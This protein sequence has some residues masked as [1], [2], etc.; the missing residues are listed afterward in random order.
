MT[1]ISRMPVVREVRRRTFR[2]TAAYWEN[3]YA[4]GGTSGA[5]S[6]GRQAEWKA[7]IVNDW[8]AELGITS[9]ID[10]GCGD[11]N[12]LTLAKYPRYLGLDPSQTA[13]RNCIERFREDKTKSFLAY[14]PATLADPAGWLRADLALSL[15][16]IFHLIEDDIFDD[17][18]NRV[19][20]SAERYV[21]ICSNDTSDD[22]RA[23]HE[24]HRDFT[25][26]ITT[27]RPQW[28]LEKRVEPPAD[29]DLQSSFFL[30]KRD[31]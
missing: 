5:G 2:S 17:Y 6:Y 30:Y 12:Q 31:A 3:R 8:V 11:G 4:S 20:D 9:V 22:E 23:A 7:E 27:N 18:M 24:R 14:D 26:W 10:L 19:F 21:V 13:V 15:E 29:V 16:V 28:K 1:T 25:K